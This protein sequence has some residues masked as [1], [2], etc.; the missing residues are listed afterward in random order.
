MKKIRINKL[1][2]FAK[3]YFEDDDLPRIEWKRMEH[4]GYSHDRNNIIYLNPDIPLPKSTDDIVTGFV[5]YKP[6]VRLRLKEG[7]QYFL[8]LLHEIGHFEQRYWTPPS[9]PEEWLSIMM[10][11]QNEKREVLLLL[12]PKDESDA[13]WRRLSAAYLL[14]GKEGESE[15]EYETRLES[16]QSWLCGDYDK[17]YQ[18]V[19][20]WAIKE[21]RKHRKRIKKI[22]GYE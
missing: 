10:K 15:E 20:E 9:I 11:M 21:F 14:D 18:A 13:L 22:L 4:M 3:L 7:E 16:L 8:T 6:S 2:D 1:R 12:P 5:K 17:A 19:E